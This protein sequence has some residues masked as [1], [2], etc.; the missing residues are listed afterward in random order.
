V[1]PDQA[2]RCNEWRGLDLYD[3]PTRYP[4]ALPDGIPATRSRVGRRRA[5]QVGSFLRIRRNVADQIGKGTTAMTLSF[6]SKGKV[7]WR[8]FGD[9]Q[10]GGCV[11]IV[12][13]I[14]QF[15]GAQAR[16]GAPVPAVLM[17][18]RHCAMER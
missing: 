11:R 2:G 13:R 12:G 10:S 5:G 16:A 6:A 1:L 7:K 4:D 18:R 8:G 17:R 9:D 3:V 15:S 14:L